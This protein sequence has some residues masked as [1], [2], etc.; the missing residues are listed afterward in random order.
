MNVDIAIIGAGP[1]GLSLARALGDKQLEV[2]VVDPAEAAALSSP[3]HDGR[4]I[5]LTHAS[6]AI[7]ER[8]DIWSRFATDDI[9]DLTDAWVFD[10]ESDQPMR[11]T[12]GDG[13][14]DQL[15]WLISNHHIRQAAWQAA[16]EVRG[17]HWLTGRRVETTR[18]K[19]NVRELV[20]SDGTV[21]NARLV[22]AADGRFS[23][24]RRS[25]GIG[26]RMRDYGK[27]MLVARMQ[28]ERDHEH[29]AWEWF[30]E[31]RTLA[32]LPLNGPYASA[33]ITLPHERIGELQAMDVD[34]FNQQVTELYRH[35]LGSMELVSERHVYPLVG[36]WPDRLTAER[37]ACLGDAAVG[38]HPV[39]AHG[40]NLG[41]TGVDLLVEEIGKARIRDGDVASP[42]RLAAYAA[43]HRA[44][45]LPLYAATATV[46]GLYTSTL[47]PARLLRRAVLQ[48]ANRLPPLRRAI[49]RQLTGTGGLFE[50]LITR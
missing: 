16:R 40:F 23:G 18:P 20:L 8:L 19:A 5:A 43:R 21:L 28:L 48:T 50:R 27:S 37:F 32:L 41:L 14:A 33:V 24:S 11:I 12:H 22:V 34:S 4:E 35:R 38:M 49:A 2:A 39:T 9:S 29:V 45:S 7:L 47:P 26:A 25:A 36:V 6:R 31:D 44:H 17:I 42:R 30:G 10:G 15:G 3:D 13:G 46:V 1:A